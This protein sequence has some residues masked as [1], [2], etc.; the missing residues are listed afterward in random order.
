VRLRLDDRLRARRVEDETP[1]IV[2][3]GVIRLRA[4]YKLP[5]LGS[6]YEVGSG[7]GEGD[8]S[9]GK[10]GSRDGRSPYGCGEKDGRVPVE[11]LGLSR[12]HRDYKTL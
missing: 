9:R 4:V 10:D 5:K 11:G 7:S 3:P 2:D 1:L 12:E 6:G 8:G